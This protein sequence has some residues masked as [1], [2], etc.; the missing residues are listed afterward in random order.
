MS[1]HTHFTP[2][3]LTAIDRVYKAIDDGIEPEII[4]VKEMVALGWEERIKNLYR[5]KDKKTGEFVFFQPNKGQS[6]YQERRTKRDEI[7]KSR[8]IGFTTWSC[9]YG[10]DRALWDA[11]STGIMSHLKEKT[12]KIFEIIKNAN[13]WF[14]RD[15]GKLYAPAQS[16]DSANSIMWEQTKASITVAYDFKSLTVRFLHA[17]EAGFIEDERLS[18]SLQSVPEEG[19]VI[20]E[21]TSNGA[22][23]MFYDNWELQKKD[24][25]NAPFRGHFFPWYENYP[26]TPEL[27]MNKSIKY[28]ERERELKEIYALED[29]HLA[30][31]RWKIYESYQGDEERFE[32]DYPSDDLSCFL[33]GHNQVFS[34]SLL[35]DQEGFV[36]DPSFVGRIETEGKKHS[37][38]RDKKGMVEIWEMPKTGVT[39]G[40]GVDIAMG[41][42]KDYSVAVVTNKKTGEMVAML[43]GFIPP[44]VMGDYVYKLGYFYNY[45]WVC[46]EVNSVGE[47]VVRDL[48]R[49][50]YSKLYK[51]TEHDEFSAVKTRKIGFSTGMRTKPKLINQ[52][53]AYCKEGR[54]RV[55]SKVLLQEMQSF[56]QLAAKGGKSLRYEAKSGKHDDTVIAAALSVEML[57]QITDVKDYELPMPE[58]MTY[59]S[60]TGFLVPNEYSADY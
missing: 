45:A 31:R 22:G 25:D 1:K 57:T 30:W 55:R 17:S 9:I 35:K 53:I 7:L 27:W 4:F 43:R 29:Y 24:P 14:K 38:Y 19:E 46:P 50:G 41:V 20:F 59:D 26:E 48:V 5:I 21:S 3:F 36:Q 13:E 16:Q 47:G 42:G 37:F 33:S 54:F 51:R 23:G 34:A 18:D 40:I 44:E 8:Q 39:Y 32:I 10:Y 58:N 2:K 28:T 12:V 49:M 60:D 56:V 52:F 6:R 15:W 11:W